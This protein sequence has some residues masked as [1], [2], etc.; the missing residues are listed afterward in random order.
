VC[1][2]DVALD[3]GSDLP[4]HPIEHLTGVA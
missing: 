4:T 2:V 3:D 1:A